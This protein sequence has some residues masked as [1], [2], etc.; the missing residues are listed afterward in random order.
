MVSKSCEADFSIIPQPG[1]GEGAAP[2]GYLD[3]DHP[4]NWSEPEDPA[5]RFYDSTDSEPDFILETTGSTI[6]TPGR[7]STE[8]STALDVSS[9]TS[10]GDANFPSLQN[11][12]KLFTYI[13]AKEKP[14]STAE[15][16]STRMP[17]GGSK[18]RSK[19]DV[20]SRKTATVSHK[21]RAIYHISQ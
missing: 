12:A 3:Y 2:R 21:N 13:P 20:S 7:Q 6:S 10:R 17:T 18:H 5:E 16:T 8:P 15:T 19:R 4:D 1:A 9:V 11:S 14:V